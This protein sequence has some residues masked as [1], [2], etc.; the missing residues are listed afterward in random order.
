MVLLIDNY[1]SFTYNLYQQIA[2]L[3]HDVIVRL[4]DDITVDEAI[5][6]SPSHIVISPGPKTPAESGVSQAI[7]Q[8][9]AASVPILGVCL[10]HQC[11][12]EVF[13]SQTVRAPAPVHG[14]I[15]QVQ[16]SGT[17]LFAGLPTAIDVARYHSLVLNKIPDQ[18]E[19][20]AQTADGLIMA[21]SHRTLPVYGIQFHPESF[22]TPAGNQLMGNFLA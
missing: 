7:I 22:M 2:G 9:F 17:G 5:A 13:G 18:F 1:D 12:G 19:L 14:K 10:G 3:G 6:L 16:H 4:H 15:S 21:I 11:I 8:Q 20:S